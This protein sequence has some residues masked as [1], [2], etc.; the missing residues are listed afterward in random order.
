MGAELSKRID[1][2]TVRR[3]VE[4]ILKHQSAN[5]AIIASPDFAEYH[6]CWLRDASFSSF[7]L[8]LAGEHEASA[9]F[10]HWANRAVSGIA[11]NIDKVTATRRQGGDPDPHEMP[12]ARF[13]LAGKI[14][15][16]D[17][18]NFQIDGYGTWLWSLGRHLDLTGHSDL[19]DEL[20]ESV[21]RVAQYLATFSLT[22]CYD[23]WEENGDALHTS[24]LA[25]VYGG[26]TAAA[27]LLR[28][29]RYLDGAVN[30]KTYLLESAIRNGYYVKSSANSN[31]DGSSLWL[32]WPFGVVDR[33]DEYFAK[34][35]SLVEDRLSLHGG[36]RRYPTDIY[37]GS[38]AWP[39]LTGSLGRHYVDTGDVEGAERCRE[40]IASHFDDL[41][42]LGE[43]YGGDERDPEHYQ[44]WVARWGLPAQDLTWSHAMYV[45]LCDAISGRNEESNGPGSR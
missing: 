42:L 40:W 18:P 1:D 23:V 36:I 30:V 37:F 19:P 31:V 9:R 44:E 22:P 7:A 43:Q 29:E 13:S 5:G 38:G 11:E 39:V 26:L 3:S 10:H 27:T 35:V 33:D 20:F 4:S 6:F 16:D 17:W 34:T 41:G 12:P 15:V 24:T 21:A 45:V 28:D 8:D 2:P 14:V 25:S 32:S